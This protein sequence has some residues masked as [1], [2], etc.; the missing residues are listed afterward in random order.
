MSAGASGSFITDVLG[1][2]GAA[3]AGGAVRNGRSGAGRRRRSV[4]R[5]EKSP[6]VIG[7]GI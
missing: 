6:R 4:E 1:S 2:A 7:W 5:G 3:V